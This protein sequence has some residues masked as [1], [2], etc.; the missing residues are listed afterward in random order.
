MPVPGYQVGE[1]LG[2]GSCGAVWSGQHL[3]TGQRVALKRIPLVQPSAG[4]SARSEAAMLATLDH[5]SLIALR[6]FIMLEHDAV[7]VLELAEGGSLTTLLSRRGR[8][9]PPEVAAS[10]SPVGAALAHA[11][12]EGVLHGDISASN[13]LFTGVGHPKLADLG[14]ARLVGSRALALG[15]PSYLDPSVAAG[16]VYGAPSDVFALG[17]VALHAATGSAPWTTG[18]GREGAAEV[19]A[20]AAT[21]RILDLEERLAGCPDAMASVLRRALDAE[22]HRRGSAAAFALDLRAATDAGR[23]VLSAGRLP[24]T[25][26]P[27]SVGRHSV[28]RLQP[29]ASERSVAVR[30]PSAAAALMPR[31]T[32]AGFVED[33]VVPAD[34]THVS[35]PRLRETVPAQV[36]RPL[37]QTAT[38]RVRAAIRRPV[39]PVLGGLCVLFAVGIVMV[40]AGVG[41]RRGERAE[42]VT[43]PAS[44]NRP[45]AA[46]VPDATT[47]LRSLDNLRSQAFALRRPE[48]LSQVYS[49]PG[50]AAQDIAQ[51]RRVAGPGC[52]VLGLTTRYSDVRV[53]SSSADR[54]AV[55]A[56]ASSPPARLSCPGHAPIS[57]PPSGPR[58]VRLVLSRT[59]SGRFAITS[60]Q[61]G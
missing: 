41:P 58:P 1:L 46:P 2:A 8:L 22:P 3:A 51:L 39:I 25:S 12:D 14:V 47:L 24:S 15:T 35:R 38:V 43:G 27:E 32:G 37:C 53:V 17:A 29:A 13:V 34:L 11:H 57:M 23:V 19:L 6:E 18:Q 56:V 10:L 50:L 44:T 20:R 49:S 59:S 55:I 60:E 31:S 33:G 54:V 61:V 16:G 36:R 48:L 45:A 26:G 40:L 42:T 4:R 5:P 28:D 21:G 52:G 9:S 30:D 7:L